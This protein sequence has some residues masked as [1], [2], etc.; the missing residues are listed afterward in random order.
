MKNRLIV[1][2]TTD[3]FRD[4][5]AAEV[6]VDKSELI[7]YTNSVMNTPQKLTCFSR[8]RRFGKTFAAQMLKSYYTRGLD[9]SDVFSNLKVAHPTEVDEVRRE[10]KRTLFKKY[11]NQCDVI[12]WDMVW[13]LSDARVD[14]QPECVLEKLRDLTFKEL[15]VVFPEEFDDSITGMAPQLMSIA[16]KTGR[17]F[18]II[19]DEWDAIFR[20]AMCSDALKDAYLN[21]LRGLFKGNYVSAF[22][23]GAY[24]T[25]IL[26]I[27]KYG[28]Q[29]ALTDFNEF[30][31]LAPYTLAPFVGFTEDE[32][33]TLC[34]NRGIDLGKMRQ[35]Y[36]GYCFTKTA[37]VFNPNSV[38]KAVNNDQFD[39]YWT[40]TAAFESLKLYLDMDFQGIRE[41]IVDMLGG[42]RFAVDKDTFTN[43]LSIVKSRNDVFT[44]LVHLGYLAYD[45]SDG[46]VAIPNEEIRREFVRSVENGGRPELVKAIELSDRLLK[47]TLREDAPAVAAIIEEL[48]YSNTAPLFYNDEQA[49]RSVVVLGYLGA[50]DH[51]RWFEEIDA[52]RGR[53]DVLMWPREGAELPPVIIELKW[54]RTA[55]SVVEQIRRRNYPAVVE[56]LVRHR[57]VLLVGISYDTE[58]RKHDCTIER[59]HL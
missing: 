19:I 1:N 48:H 11:Q 39:S 25:G 15:K 6:F 31:M 5:V 44:V 40:Q 43:D 10:R 35:W 17:K 28:T 38:V 20:E 57:E 45:E 8:P 34:R 7:H 51:Y 13:F 12:L 24:L 54:N 30:T 36:D 9:S 41:A 23:S 14:G 32:V 27:K 46:T 18:F 37:H 21:L 26:P 2:P 3:D 52:G 29:S 22:I 16:L 42:N 56:K 47:A 59:L 53:I 4:A 58:T 50:V 49:L 33:V 55:A